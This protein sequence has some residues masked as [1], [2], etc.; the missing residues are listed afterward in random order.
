MLKTIPLP[1]KTCSPLIS[2][3]RGGY[4]AFNI[5]ENKKKTTKD[6]AKFEKF[7]KIY[8]IFC[9]YVFIKKTWSK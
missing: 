7:F 6:F 9:F 5:G 2:K 4:T 8:T 3:P 1:P